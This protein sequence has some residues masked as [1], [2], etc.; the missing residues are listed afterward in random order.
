MSDITDK[1]LKRLK[2]QLSKAKTPMQKKLI[3]DKINKLIKRTKEPTLGK[4]KLGDDPRKLL[5]PLKTKKPRSKKS[6][7]SNIS[8][9]AGRYDSN[10]SKEY[11]GEST[12]EDFGEEGNF[13]GGQPDFL[14]GFRDYNE[15]YGF[16]DGG[17]IKKKIKRVALRGGRKET[18]GT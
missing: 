17:S 13:E 15:A 12:W 4:A 5:K 18:R 6:L 11:L 14:E 1:Q 7:I 9:M 10:P 2:T 16:N 3:T 8:D